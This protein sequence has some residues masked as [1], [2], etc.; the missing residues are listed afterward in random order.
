MS[1]V[2][3]LDLV[4]TDTST[5][6]VLGDCFTSNIHL[7]IAGY[8]KSNVAV[9]PLHIRQTHHLQQ[10]QEGSSDVREG[11]EREKGGRER[12]KGRGREWG[13]PLFVSYR[14]YTEPTSDTLI[15]QEAVLISQT[16]L[17]NRR[18]S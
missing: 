8:L 10:D 2:S 4:S 14:W 11:G 17:T 13:T 6:S 15:L 1:T 18:T 5:K 12:K 3:Y 16:Y 9:T 7:L